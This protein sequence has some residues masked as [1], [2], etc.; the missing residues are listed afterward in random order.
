MIRSPI[1]SSS[2]RC[3]AK[4]KA[5][6]SPEQITSWCRLNITLNRP[7]QKDSDFS[8]HTSFE[9]VSNHP[10]CRY[11][12]IRSCAHDQSLIRHLALRHQKVRSC[13]HNKADTMR[14]TKSWRLMTTT[15]SIPQIEKWYESVLMTLQTQ[16]KC[17]DLG[18]LW[19]H[20]AY[21]RL[22]NDKNLCL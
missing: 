17:Q 20:Q 11:P 9:E 1:W 19:K 14:M 3:G 4:I 22:K 21:S 7:V 15:S 6:I 18:S 13:A 16:C 10:P 2:S 12:V 5:C 8:Y